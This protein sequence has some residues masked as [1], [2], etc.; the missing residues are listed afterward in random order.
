MFLL[1]IGLCFVFL[2]D[3]C[4]CLL[5]FGFVFCVLGL[6]SWIWIRIWVFLLKNFWACNFLFLIFF[7]LVKIN[8]LIFFNLNADV[9]FFN[10]KKHFFIINLN[11]VNINLVLFIPAV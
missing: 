10:T 3:L 8:K 5:C 7:Y 11:H 2:L 6:C 1:E 4:S 9:T